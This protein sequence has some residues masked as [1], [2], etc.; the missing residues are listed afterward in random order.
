MF[1]LAPGVPFLTKTELCSSR[2]NLLNSTKEV[3]IL[4]SYSLNLIHYITF[5]NGEHAACIN[6]IKWTLTL[7]TAPVKFSIK[8]NKKTLIKRKIQRY[9]QN[10]QIQENKQHFNK[11]GI[12]SV[13]L[14]TQNETVFFF[15]FKKFS[16][17][18]SGGPLS[19]NSDNV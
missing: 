8:D 18:R 16:F 17:S 12:N 13:S 9:V 10:L 1:V 2:K 7:Q 5:Y 19:G 3:L 6:R 15:Y 4:F 11:Y 14:L